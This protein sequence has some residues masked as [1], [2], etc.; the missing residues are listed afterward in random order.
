MIL[1]ENIYLLTTESKNLTGFGCVKYWQRTKSSPLEYCTMQYILHMKSLPS[2]HL[3]L[4]F[5]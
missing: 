2:N 1:C 4:L 3:K 5:T